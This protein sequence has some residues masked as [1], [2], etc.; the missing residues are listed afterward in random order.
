MKTFIF[1]LVVVMTFIFVLHAIAQTVPL[2]AVPDRILEP[3]DETTLVALKGNVH[4][5][6]RTQV[7]ASTVPPSTATGRVRLLLQKSEGQQLALTQYL[8]DVRNPSSVNYHKWLTP[9]EYGA[10]FGAS[11]SDLQRVQTWLQSHG[12]KIE[13]VPQAHNV[14]EFSGTVSQIENS[15]HSSIKN[16]S[17]NGEFHLANATD[18]E[19]PAALAPVVA[20]IGPLNSFHA[21]PLSVRGAKGRFDPSTDRITPELTLKGN[22]STYLFVDPADAAVIYDTTNKTLNPGYNGTTY[23]GTGIAIGIVGV[24]DLTLAD[25]ANYRTAFLG[26]NS[27]SV[28]LP[29]VVVD[30]NDPGLNSAG[31]EALLDT[32]IAGGIAPKAKLY[33]Y[34]SADT[35]LS[36]GLMN[37][38]FRALDDNVVSILSMS[39]G[40]CEAA[41]GTSGNQLM[42][43]AAEQAAAQGITLTVSTGDS[44]SAGCDNFD[45]QTTATQGIGVNG[46]ASTPYTVA[47]GGT[48]FDVLSG[49][50]A[51][52]VTNTTSGTG[53][54]YA[55]ALK[56][57]PESPWNDSTSVNKTYSGNT[58]AKNIQGNGN[59][60]AGSGGASAVY[61]KPSY[62]GS[63][64]PQDGFRDLPDVSFLAGNGVYSATWVVCSDGTTDGLSTAGADC[65]TTN[66]QFTANTTFSGIGGTSAAAPAFAGMLALLAQAHGEASDN[67]R[68]GQVN[69]IL[70]QLAQSK[71][72]TVF[73]DVTTGNNSVACTAGSP[74]CG[75]N[76]FL[77]GYNAGTGYD[78]ASGLGS[79]DVAAMVSNWE[80]VAPGTTS[81]S[82]K[83]NGS[84]AAYS[85]VHGSTL[86]FSTDVTGSSGTP[87]GVVAITD[88]AGS[89]TSGAVSSPQ[90][91]GQMAISLTS[92][93]GSAS[94]NGL[95][96]GSYQ[97]SA[98]YGGDPAFSASISAPIAVSI[99]AEPSTT[100]LSV[101]GYDPLTGNTISGASFPYG[102]YVFSD[103]AITGTAEGSHTQGLATGTVTF[104][105]GATTLGTAAVSSGNLASWPPFNSSSTPVAAGTYNLLAKYSGDSSY[106]PSSGTANFVVTKAPTMIFADYAGTPV[107]YGDQEQIGATVLT[108][109]TG[110]APTGTFQFYVD[111][112]PAGAP[113]PVYESSGYSHTNGKNNWAT[114]D[115]ISTYTFTS[116]GQHTLSVTY[117]GDVNYA[118]GTSAIVDVPVTQGQAAING[119]GFSDPQGQPVVVG[120][121]ATGIA[122][123]IGLGS[124]PAPTGTV[125]FYDGNTALTDPVSYTT[126]GVELD[127]T[128]EHVFTSAG[129]H[130]ISVSYSGNANYTSATTPVPQ[131]LNVL[132]PLSLSAGTLNALAAGQTGTVTVTVTANAG[133][134][135]AVS[136]SCLVTTSLT[137]NTYPPTCSLP[138]SVTISGTSSASA[139]LTVGTTPG[140][141]ARIKTPSQWFG[142]GGIVLAVLFLFGIPSRRRAWRVVLC[143][144]SVAMIS[145]IGCGGGASGSGGGGGSRVSGT[146]PGAYVVTVT[147]TDAAT[148]K[149]TAQ[150]TVPFTVD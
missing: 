41:L 119:Y 84:V 131:A 116:L 20:G 98:R 100:T 113:Q 3:I 36:S 136:L 139:T 28:N 143:I 68:L 137:G 99:S 22:S 115:A 126:S 45:T 118:G 96:G 2:T 69:D 106:T 87:T 51:S 135:G 32:E 134:T 82:L 59:I 92:G 79:V 39:F 26:E 38:L 103:A 47:V 31:I 130:Q 33:F 19:I 89:T 76:G 107:Q 148:G 34:T 102:S 60:V 120:Q 54:Y 142:G 15:F 75:S 146:T 138:S 122:T 58:A 56:Y 85:G 21:K 35:D 62:Q 77:T 7:A 141:T 9:T 124:G 25:V 12:F 66:G 8:T 53:P 93:S 123:V 127:A 78:L 150:T 88:N 117:S 95:P 1:G 24:S 74:E 144:A 18:P 149:I 14:I 49:S 90:N 46:Y 94:Y 11:S 132:G 48:D 140:S 50:F 13:K 71:Y 65:L 110:I 10:R 112:H 67:Y 108:T 55:T 128:T 44:G 5:L 145:A 86:T 17:A 147:G 52:Y 70:Y 121:S 40:T 125:T 4:P 105:N 109:S 72:S 57:I 111:G 91:N 63:I 23:D 101:N 114:A 42:L 81:T 80:S 43:E 83:I 30:G 27:T 129:V 64:T 133:F 97:I 6:A 104:S 73:H 29:T 61:P 37:A 16:L